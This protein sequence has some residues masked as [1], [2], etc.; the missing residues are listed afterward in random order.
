[1]NEAGGPH[2]PFIRRLVELS[3]GPVAVPVVD[4]LP[5]PGVLVIEKEDTV[6][7]ALA[8]WLLHQGFAV[9]TAVD[10]EEALAVYQQHRS[11]ITLVV[12]ELRTYWLPP[13]DASPQ[14]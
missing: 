5:S 7:A 11:A 3:A 2:L 12:E 8:G 13:R 6:R 10:Q 4:D 14:R 1:M 9:W